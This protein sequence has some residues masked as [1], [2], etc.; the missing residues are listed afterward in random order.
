MPL[1][2]T[3]ESDLERLRF[4]FCEVV[5]VLV[6]SITPGEALRAGRFLTGDREWRE[7]RRRFFRLE[8]SREEEDLPELSSSLELEEEEEDDDEES[9]LLLLLS[10]SLSLLTE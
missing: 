5:V 1:R 3:G 10:L 2:C 6:M 8:D 4:N 7:R 9:S